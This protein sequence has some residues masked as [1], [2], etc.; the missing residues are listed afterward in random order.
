M[1]FSVSVLMKCLLGTQMCINHYFFSWAKFDY[2]ACLKKMHW[3]KFVVRKYLKQVM[4]IFSISFLGCEQYF[5][6]LLNV[7]QQ[8]KWLGIRIQMMSIPIFGIDRSILVSTNSWDSTAIQLRCE[9]SHSS[10]RLN[11]VLRAI[12]A[13]NGVDKCFFIYLKCPYT[14]LSWN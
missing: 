1:L 4:N 13:L 7:C 10:W 8:C 11:A 14:L 12:K 2:L 5:V 9:T 6:Q 3:K